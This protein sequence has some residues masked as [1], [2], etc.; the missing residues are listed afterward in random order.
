MATCWERAV[1]WLFTCAFFI[2]V[3]RAGNGIRLVYGTAFSENE[4]CFRLFIPYKLAYMFLYVLLNSSNMMVVF[5]ETELMGRY[6]T[7]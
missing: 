4:N 3:F 2:L 7:I 5:N 1:P 6:N